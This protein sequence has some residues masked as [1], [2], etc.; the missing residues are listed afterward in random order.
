M[1]EE[2]GRYREKGLTQPQICKN[3]NIKANM[4]HYPLKRLEETKIV[5]DFSIPTISVFDDLLW[6]L[7]LEKQ[8]KQML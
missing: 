1:L 2:V 3:L 5:Y 8:L 6:F 4:I 7:K